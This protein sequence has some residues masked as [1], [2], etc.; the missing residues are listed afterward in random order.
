MSPFQFTHLWLSCVMVSRP[1]CIGLAP[2]GTQLVTCLCM[3]SQ[4]GR[5]RKKTTPTT[6][7]H[8][9]KNQP[10]AESRFGFC[11]LDYLSTVRKKN[12]SGNGTIES[13]KVYRYRFIIRY[14]YRTASHIVHTYS[15][16]TAVLPGIGLVCLRLAMPPKRK[17]VSREFIDDSDDPEDTGVSWFQL[18]L[19]QYSVPRLSVQYSTYAQY[20]ARLQYWLLYMQTTQIQVTRYKSMHYMMPSSDVITLC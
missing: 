1:S 3:Q 15:I 8:A 6:Q 5:N 16:T 13:T 20:L 17:A 11:L 10:R 4:K 14:S 7:V 9:D 18:H 12:W 19:L 2:F